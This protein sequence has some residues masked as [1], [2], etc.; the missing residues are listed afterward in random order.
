MKAIF[1]TSGLE[2]HTREQMRTSIPQQ[3]HREFI[4][5]LIGSL[6]L[7]YIDRLL[8]SMPHV[9]MWD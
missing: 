5:S 6:D 3:G 4:A 2:P 7:D 8:K 1:R 9:R